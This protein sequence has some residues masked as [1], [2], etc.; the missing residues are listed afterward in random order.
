[1]TW[2]IPSLPAANLSSIRNEASV[3]F[4]TASLYFENS[5]FNFE[6][7]G[8]YYS[9]SLQA[10]IETKCL[11]IHIQN[12][13]FSNSCKSAHTNGYWKVFSLLGPTPYTIT[14]FFLKFFFVWLWS[15]M[16]YVPDWFTEFRIQFLYIVVDLIFIYDLDQWYDLF[17]QNWMTSDIW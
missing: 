11:S 13:I 16:V 9:T 17:S 6:R 2:T 12:Y 7:L 3:L 1:M 8:I 15:R 4:V 5:Y 10:N 14:H